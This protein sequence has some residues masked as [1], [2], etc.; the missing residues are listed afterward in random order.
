MS[1]MSRTGTGNEPFPRPWGV[2]AS[3]SYQYSPSGGFEI[4]LCRDAARRFPWHLHAAH[5]VAGAALSGGLVLETPLGARRIRTGECF[6]IPRLRAHRLTLD[7]GTTLLTVCRA[8][9]PAAATVWRLSAARAVCAG[10]C[11]D[12]REQPLCARHLDTAPLTENLPAATPIQS[13]CRLLLSD[14]ATPRPLARL[15]ALTGYSPWHFLRRFRRETGLTPH[16]FQMLG[17][18]RLARALLRT[19]TALAE[20][21]AAAGFTDQS[22]MHKAFR[23]QHNLTPK[24]FRLA[25]LRLEA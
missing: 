15:A 18:L 1:G 8:S 4:V 13:V 19:D 3:V 10:L 14:P 23:R 17:R 22:H 16:A 6:R 11:P 9:A 21:A 2:M 7:P 12:C 5:E 24:Q 25:S 20:T